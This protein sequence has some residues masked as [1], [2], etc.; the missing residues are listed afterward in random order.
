MGNN[1]SVKRPPVTC[2]TLALLIV[3]VTACTRTVHVRTR[4]PQASPVAIRSGCPRLAGQGAPTAPVGDNTPFELCW[5]TSPI[6]T[7]WFSAEPSNYAENPEP[8][9]GYPSIPIGVNAPKC[10]LP[11][12]IQGALK[13]VGKTVSPT[14]IG[15]AGQ[16]TASVG[17]SSPAPS[18]N[19]EASGEKV[20]FDQAHWQLYLESKAPGL[21]TCFVPYDPVG[22]P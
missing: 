18:P 14:P 20:F 1:A 22:G 17:Q 16:F 12:K 7:R 8:V 2:L 9:P 19:G 3:A 10:V 13:F 15:Y 11:S 6:F 5:P 4:P 21:G